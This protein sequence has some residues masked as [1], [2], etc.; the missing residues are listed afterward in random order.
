MMSDLAEAITSL[1][2]PVHG[3]AI[4]HALALRDLLDARI[5]VAVGEYDHEGL[6]ELDGA[7]STTAF[8]R[9]C[10]VANAASL[11]KTA[12]R[13][14]T[15]PVIKAAWLDRTL[16]GGQIQAVCANVDDATLGLLQE[17][18]AD[19]VPR[20]APLS[21]VDTTV[22]MRVWKAMA[23]ARVSRDEP[24]D[25]ER[26]ASLSELL[27][28]RGRFDANLDR[29]GL[30]LARKALR[31]ATSKDAEGEERTAAQRRGDAF[32]DILR[33]FLDHQNHVPKNRNRPHVDFVVDAEKFAEDGTGATFADGTPTDAATINRIMCD[34]GISRLVTGGR[35]VILD[36]GTTQYPFSDAQ[37]QALVARDRHCR[38]PDCDRPPEW[39]EVHHVIPWPNGPT[40]LG[41]GLLKCNR[42]HQLGH[43]PGW[44]E[45]LEPDGTYHLTA[46]DG[47]TWTTTP[48]GVLTQAA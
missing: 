43:R 21:I 38:H 8:V 15:L 11:V 7:T 36:Y 4:A 19:L 2:I 44:T 33:F 34:A 30:Q 18:E 32:V 35:S 27:D 39:C 37:F 17:H 10:G 20:L 42:H 16:S 23:D 25:H 48:P 9:Q 22:A 45:T 47:R 14:R 26:T 40:N 24:P 13:V 1:E 29:E 46:P 6:A 41:N 3:E 12:K 28:G 31:L 5:A